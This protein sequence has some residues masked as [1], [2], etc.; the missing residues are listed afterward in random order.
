MDLFKRLALSGVG[1]AFVLGLAVTENNAQR[2]G[3][4]Y[5]SGG[6]SGGYVRYQP[7]YSGTYGRGRSYVRYN[8]GYAGLGNRRSYSGNRYGLSW[9]ERRILAIRRARAIR[10]INRYQ[11]TRSRILSR[12]TPYR[13]TYYYRNW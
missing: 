11:R 6:W 8:T 4:Y 7:R 5:G 10:A 1:L 13:N 12:R 2:N 9:R 3:R